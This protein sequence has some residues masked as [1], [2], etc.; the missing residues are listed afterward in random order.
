M[1]RRIFAYLHT[2]WDREW[3]RNK[4]DFNIR[5]LDVF[6]TVID[7]LVNN[8]APFFYLDGQVIA[9]LDYLKYRESKKDTVIN[10]IKKNKL[11]I[12]P[13][14]ASIDSYL[15]NFCSMLKNL[16]IGINISKEF[17][18]KDFIG[19]MADIF[20]ISNSAFEALKIKEIDKAIIW[21]GV[22][23]KSINNNC[24][25]IKNNIET[26]WLAQGYFND[27]FHTGNIEGIKNYIDKIA[28]Y[29]ENSILLPIGG[30]H[31]NILCDADKKIKQIN[32]VLNDYE[33]ILTSPFEYFK[34]NKFNFK[35]PPHEFLDN[36][37][38]Y[39]LPGVYS[40]RI[41]Q[42]IL[43]NKVQTVLSRILEPINEFESGKY[44]KNIDNVYETL[45][46]NYAHDGIYGC[47]TDEVHRTVEARFNKCLQASQS[48]IKNIIADYK[49][50]NNITGKTEDK[51]EIFNLS[52]SK[53][54][55]FKI[56]TPYKIKN[57]QII[58]KEK[59]FPDDILF[60]INK[61]PV[62]E[63][64]TTI[65]TSLIQTDFI[66]SFS[67]KTAKITLPKKETKI[68]KN[69]IENKNIKLEVKQNNAEEIFITDKINK[70]KCILKLTDIKDNGDSYNYAPYGKK[71]ILNIKNTKIIYDGIIESKL[72]IEYKNIKLYAKLNNKSEF[73]SFEAVINN[74]KKNHKLQAVFISEKNIKNTVSDE[75][76]GITERNIDCNYDM[77]DNMPA[78][79]PFELKTNSYPM[80]SFVSANNLSVITKG[81]NEYEIYKNELRICLLRATGT[82]SNPKNAARA[83]PAGPDLKCED[84]QY[85]NKIII[86]QFGLLFN[87]HIGVYNN[88]DLFNEIYLAA[89]GVYTKDD[90]LKYTK[91]A[92]YS[93]IYWISQNQKLSYNISKNKLVYRKMEKNYD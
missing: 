19:Y 34:N 86:S 77:Q 89:D 15:V 29:S 39:I 37:N 4:E 80:Q 53:N 83:I 84:S 87:N 42:K 1:K 16:E 73:I 54:C 52:N 35:K 76:I 12:G 61:V 72:L 75:A 14:F 68:T 22:N 25:F 74:K 3:Y 40:T 69:S 58:S 82:I 66:E 36:S 48:M 55:I 63:E 27:F 70:K 62:T 28:K 8:K 51:V 32:K 47:S 11:A 85:I 5:L 49:K 6:D 65:Y 50:K 33:I 20:G 57:S 7:E 2:H 67:K 93:Y 13:Y 88:I 18:Q 17:G 78:K 26:V 23:P 21:R 46:K 90:N 30:D 60:D 10:L 43:N 59:G 81:L 38:T 92:N 41:D 91:T 56:K 44:Y 64:I 45:I 71:E 24:N 9:L 31:L 79:R